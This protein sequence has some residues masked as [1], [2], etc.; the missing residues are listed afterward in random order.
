MSR[1]ATVLTVVVLGGM[2]GTGLRFGV[3]S[4]AES[5]GWPV[6]VALLIVNSFGA[7][8]LGWFV[9]WRTRPP[10]P[11]IASTLMSAGVLASFTTFSGVMVE[12]AELARS[13]QVVAAAALLGASLGIGWLCALSGRHVASR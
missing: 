10:M 12:A 3:A 4:L 8:F 9:E 5:R 1:V 6:A 7:F 2:V 11:D 13:A